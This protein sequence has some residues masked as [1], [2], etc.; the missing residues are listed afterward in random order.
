[1]KKVFW[2]TVFLLVLL[3]VGM[4]LA[5]IK[6]ARPWAQEPGG[7]PLVSQSYVAEA[8]EERLTELEN[9]VAALHK[10][11]QKLTEEMGR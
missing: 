10:R 11:V 2:Q 1:M 4:G 5:Q 8:I 9:R 7:D 3:G 6:G